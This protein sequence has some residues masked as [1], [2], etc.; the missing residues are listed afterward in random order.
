MRTTLSLD[1]DVARQLERLQREKQASWKDLVN[2]VLRQGLAVVGSAPRRSRR[3][4]R[5]RPVSA[6]RLLIP[7]I[8]D[9]T[10]ALE[11]AEGDRH[12]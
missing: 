2:E 6:G 7:S 8:D 11:I 10:T 4:Y 3:T 12:R 9:V 5:T 1:D